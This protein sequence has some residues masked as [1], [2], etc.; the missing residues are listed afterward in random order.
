MRLY[1]ITLLAADDE[2]SFNEFVKEKKVSKETAD[3]IK[4]LYQEAAIPFRVKPPAGTAF[5][6]DSE[7]SDRAFN[8]LRDELERTNKLELLL[9]DGKIEE[10]NKA[11]KRFTN[12][13][14]R[15]Y[16]NSFS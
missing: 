5:S 8:M 12:K 3:Y 15:E 11:L 7:S 2:K 10:Y 13:M 6:D 16:R 1:L 9:H 14:K 4:K